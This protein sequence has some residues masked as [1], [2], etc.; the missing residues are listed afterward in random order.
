VDDGDVAVLLPG[1]RRGAHKW[2]TAV[3]VVAGSPGMR[4]A[5]V[6][7]ARA[8][9]R[10]GA[11]M[12]QVA[13]PGVAAADYP[14]GEA[15][16]QSL[17]GEDW[18]VDVL[19][20]VC[21]FGAVVVG[22][23][24][25]RAPAASAGVRK[26]VVSSPVPVVVDADGLAALGDADSAASVIRAAKVPVVLTPH[27]GEFGRLN[28]GPPSVDRLEAVRRLAQ[29]TGAIVLLKGP[30]TVVADPLGAV[31]LAAAGDARL[32]T[33]G[34]G[35]VLAGMVGAFLAAR[36]APLSAAALAAH[37]HGRAATLGPKVGLVAGDLVDLIPA[38]LDP[39]NSRGA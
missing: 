12:V 15:V 36:V 38:A 30:T 1:R 22:P 2:D 23:G 3:F 24:L 32:A 26:L 11:G 19:A 37:V 33:A 29:R 34:T 17:P 16:A 18:D 9:Q 8:A 31:L 4:G 35:D 14:A 13:S 21:R 7:C 10:A 28:G 39:A 6:L 27:E 20:M 5:A 25:G